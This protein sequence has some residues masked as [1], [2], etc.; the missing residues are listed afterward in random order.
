MSLSPDPLARAVLD[1]VPLVM[2]FIRTHMRSQ[3]SDLRI[4]Q[5]RAL[6]FINRYPEGPLIDLAEHL[7]LAPPSA[8]ALVDGLV[9][10]GLVDRR[11]SN[12]DRRRITLTLTA[13]GLGILEQA[14]RSTLNALADVLA[15]LPET[16]RTEISGSLLALQAVFSN[17][18]P[19]DTGSE[20][21]N[22][23]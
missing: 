2:R 20:G 9:K 11:P 13:A 5:F 18:V 7:G 1:V 6:L 21:A 19:G 15:D 8:S 16:R 10:R 17:P 23:G 14:R 12:H 4:S 3:R 22:H